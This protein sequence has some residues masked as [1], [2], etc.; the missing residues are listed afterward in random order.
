MELFGGITCWVLM[1]D[2]IEEIYGRK[3][4]ERG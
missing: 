2:G 1:N 3:V 4:K